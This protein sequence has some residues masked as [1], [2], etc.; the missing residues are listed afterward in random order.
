MSE[1]ITEVKTINGDSIV[2]AGN[3]VVTGS[4]PAI[5]LTKLAPT[6]SQTITAGYSGY[7]CGPYEIVAGTSF[8]IGAGAC[9]EIG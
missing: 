2:G 8:E 7:V 5:P 6:T 9:F 1:V 4:Q 3:L